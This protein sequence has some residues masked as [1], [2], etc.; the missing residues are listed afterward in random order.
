MDAADGA[1][2]ALEGLEA[3][4][5]LGGTS[6]AVVAVLGA[7]RERFAKTAEEQGAFDLLCSDVQ[8]WLRRE[9]EALRF[10]KA[11]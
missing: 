2:A 7:L 11:H 4:D 5:Q 3:H 9:I 6:W 10:T 1:L 8:A